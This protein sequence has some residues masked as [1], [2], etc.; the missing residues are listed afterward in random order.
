L[1]KF[2][3][4]LCTNTYIYCQRVKDSVTKY[5]LIFSSHNKTYIIITIIGFKLVN[6]IKELIN[7]F[8]LK[9]ITD[10]W[11]LKK[12]KQLI[13]LNIRFLSHFNSIQ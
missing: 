1:G 3:V 12:G 6:Q 5:Q 10:M 8:K 11:E 13:A 9:A 7:K 2:V 4:N